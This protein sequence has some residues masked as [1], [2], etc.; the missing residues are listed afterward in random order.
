MFRAIKLILIASLLS[1]AIASPT[2]FAQQ[3]SS[4]T[5]SS[6]PR[7]H[8]ATIVFAGLAGAVLGLSTLSFYG[9]PQ[10]KLN[11]IGI[12]AAIGVFVGA[13]YTAVQATTKPKDFYGTHSEFETQMMADRTMASSQTYTP[14]LGYSWTF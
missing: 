8:I 5:K 13:G 11:N 9:R 1:L 14:Q 3:G 12:G 2:S 6:G 7:K 10:E 4:S